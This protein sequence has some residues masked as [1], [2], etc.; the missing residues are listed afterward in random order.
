MTRRAIGIVRVSRVGGREGESFASPDEQ[1]ER[2]VAACE[3]DGMR[4]VDVIE[5]LDTSGGAPLAKRELRRA[6]EAVEQGRAN[7]LVAAYFDRLVRSLR[8]QQEIVERV[9]AAGGSILALDF[10]EVTDTT[11]AHWLSST[12]IGAVAEYHRRSARERSNEAKARAVARGV[13][14]WPDVPVGYRRAASGRFEPDDVAPLVRRGFEL[15][16]DGATIREVW[17]MMVEGGA[18][19]TL[20]QARRMLTN[21]VY[22]GEIRHGPHTNPTAHEPIV[23][24]GL[25]EAVQ[26]VHV[27][28]GPRAKSDRLLA[29]LGVLRCAG[30]NGRMGVSSGRDGVFY[31]CPTPTSGRYCPLRMTVYCHIAEEAVVAEVRKAL[32]GMRGRASTGGDAR[33]AEAEAEEAQAALDHAIRAF[34]AA[35]VLDEPSAADELAELRRR[36]DEAVRRAEHLRGLSS[37]ATVNPDA[38]WDLLT[39]DEQR[40]LIRAVVARAVVNPGRGPGRITVEFVG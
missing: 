9:E 13:A 25:F 1:R 2:I 11:A 35:G 23:D 27:P 40:A 15:R 18:D 30:C 17:Q 14:P 6:V 16:A 3:R 36:R 10:G 38:D 28:R 20:A 29:R 32:A 7:V 37:V 33:R 34:S 24:P 22:L 12:M 5:E 26:R 4:L 21:R 19:V 8:V 39:L 31:R